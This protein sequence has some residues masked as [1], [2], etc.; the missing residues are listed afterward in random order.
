MLSTLFTK[1]QCHSTRA[2][3]HQFKAKILQWE[4]LETSFKKKNARLS[5]FFGNRE[6]T[7]VKRL[8]GNVLAILGGGFSNVCFTFMHEFHTF[9]ITIS[10]I[11]SKL[12]IWQL[13][14]NQ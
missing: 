1:H 8:S 10:N 2:K 7:G 3:K 14:G 9:K 6:E 4:K 5:S 11:T 13:L 12:R